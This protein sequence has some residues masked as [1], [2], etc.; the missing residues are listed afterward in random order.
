MLGNPQPPNWT[1]APPKTL[2]E[3][4]S[5]LDDMKT[6]LAAQKAP[7]SSSAWSTI[8]THWKSTANGL[9]AAFITGG[10]ILVATP[11]PI[12]TPKVAT[13]ITLGL[14]LARAY[15]GMI[16]KDAS[17]LTAADISKQTAVA[18]AKQT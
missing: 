17:S 16:S 14:A 15:V 5:E 4:Q 18:T 6:Q 2:A 1:P 3:L 13:Y 9:L 12:V 8:F 10:V 7:K 11:N